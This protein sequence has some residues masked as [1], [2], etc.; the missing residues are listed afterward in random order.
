MAHLVRVLRQY[1]KG[2]GFKFLMSFDF[3][4]EKSFHLSEEF[5]KTIIIKLF[6][7]SSQKFA[8]FC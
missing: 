4:Q 3:N 2:R 8:S 6:S 7:P 1:L 5:Y